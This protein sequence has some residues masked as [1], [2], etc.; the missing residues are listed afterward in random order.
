MK[1]KWTKSDKQEAAPLNLRKAEPLAK[2]SESPRLNR[3]VVANYYN[4]HAEAAT[5]AGKFRELPAETQN[6]PGIRKFFSSN[7]GPWIWNY[8]KFAFSPRAPFPTYA[9]SQK[10]GVYNID[11]GGNGKPVSIAIAGDW[12][13][14]TLEA[15][16]TG[17]KISEAKPD[18]TIHLGDVYYVGDKDEIEQ[19]YLGMPKKGYDGVTWPKGAKGSFALNGNH[20]MYAN[21]GPYFNMLLPKL[22]M[23]GDK[24]GQKASYFCLETEFWR[25]IAIDTGYHSVGFPVL[26]QIPGVKELPFIGGNCHLEKSVVDWLRDVVGVSSKRKPTV[27]LGHHNYFSAFGEQVYAKPAKQIASLFGDQEIIWI[28]G[29]EHRL[30]LYEKHRT[31]EGMQVHGRCIGHGG[32]P[33][34]AE[35]PKS[36]SPALSRYDMRTH[37]LDDGSVVGQNGFVRVSLHNQTLGLTYCDADGALLL[38][39]T[40]TAAANLALERKIVADKGLLTKPGG[41]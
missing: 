25:I 18:F 24:E 14:G 30:A 32:M 2:L 39:E 23:S 26:S 40:F 33:I 13:T 12:G 41:V 8:L 35:R 7:F 31:A 16:M 28:W 10:N 15:W 27:L 34:K 21:G 1:N 38:E 11:P 22:G 9:T 19:N 6:F 17:Q 29:H 36:A 5:D 37:K 3:M 4:K 20:E